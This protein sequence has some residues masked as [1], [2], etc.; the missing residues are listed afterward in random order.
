M[1]D[2]GDSQFLAVLVVLSAVVFFGVTAY[3]NLSRE[4]PAWTRT[5]LGVSA[6]V[7]AVSALFTLF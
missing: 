2:T 4:V 3:V 1:F 6:L 5:A 7:L